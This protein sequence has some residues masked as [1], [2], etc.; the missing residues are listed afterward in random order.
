MKDVRGRTFQY[1]S[2]GVS[3][4]DFDRSLS[5]EMSGQADE[6][7][8]QKLDDIWLDALKKQKAKKQEPVFAFVVKTKNK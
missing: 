7:K 6:D 8:S 5:D 2:D 1:R 3:N 4:D